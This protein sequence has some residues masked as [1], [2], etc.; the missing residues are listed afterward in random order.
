MQSAK[1]WVTRHGRR[2]DGDPVVQCSRL[3]GWLVSRSSWWCRRRRRRWRDV[4]SWGDGIAYDNLKGKRLC[5]CCVRCEAR[6]GRR[7]EGSWGSASPATPP[8]F[9]LREVRCWGRRRGRSLPRPA[10]ACPAL[11]DSAR[12]RPRWIVQ[13]Q[14]ALGIESDPLLCWP[15]QM[16]ILPGP[17]RL[18]SARPRPRWIESMPSGT[19][20][21]E[22]TLS[23]ADRPKCHVCTPVYCGPVSTQHSNSTLSY[24]ST[25]GL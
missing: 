13:C 7:G 12:L 16:P 5:N 22:A 19:G 21:L 18:G 15:S 10:R 8:T 25:A 4:S 9:R 1:E 23:Y 2:H 24:F 11:P 3:G 6:R 17:A 20:V 14:V